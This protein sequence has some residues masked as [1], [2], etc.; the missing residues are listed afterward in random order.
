RSSDIFSLG[1]LFH[2]LLFCRDPFHTEDRREKLRKNRE[3]KVDIPEGLSPE[4]ARLMERLLERDHRKRFRTAVDLR[5][6]LLK[7]GLV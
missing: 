5:E 4:V 1:C 7:E 2:F 3:G 6:Y